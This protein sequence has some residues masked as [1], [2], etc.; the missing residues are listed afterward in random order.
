MIGSAILY[1][2]C[3]ASTIGL[4][5][6][7]DNRWR[8]DKNKIKR[9]FCFVL[10]LLPCSILSGLRFE[11]GVDYV[12]YR[13]F[14][15]YAASLDFFSYLRAYSEGRYELEPLYQILNHICFIFKA[16][17]QWVLFFSTFITLFFFFKAI[18]KYRQKLNIFFA[19]FIYLMMLFQPSLNIV[20]QEMAVTIVFYAFTKLLDK[21]YIYYICWVIIGMGFHT[22]A[23]I[24]IP[25]MILYMIYYSKAKDI[26]K[27]LLIAL[28]LGFPLYVNL[29]LESGIFDFL[30]T[31][32]N[33]EYT[34][35][36]QNQGFGY[37]VFFLPLLIPIFLL[38]KGGKDDKRVLFEL[39]F[40][41][42]ISEMIF[43]VLTYSYVWIGRLEDYFTIYQC[44]LVPIMIS[45][46]K[47]RSNKWIIYFYYSIYYFSMYI[48]TFYIVNLH[49]TYPYTS[50]L[51]GE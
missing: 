6:L 28:V 17:Y 51:K 24:G 49:D 7:Y 38:Y 42:V 44:I 32:F 50:I 45:L 43:R 10:I 48:Y 12:N 14:Y 29:I 40:L 41:F 15:Q 46:L 9:Y 1:L 13:T 22:S 34:M 8:N 11:V 5:R 19:S 30:I 21:K 25:I 36:T 33:Y 35:S 39:T 47:R 37:L 20:R 31:F 23:I 26:Y 3:F 18:L 27:L 4:F 2:S 16:G